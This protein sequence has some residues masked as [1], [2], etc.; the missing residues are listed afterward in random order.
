M[1]ERFRDYCR[2]KDKPVRMFGI[3]VKHRWNTTYLMLRQLKGYEEIISVFINSL[4]FRRKFLKYFTTI[5]HLYCFALV[6]DPRK[7]LE[8]VEAAFISIGDAVGLDYSEAYQHARDELFR[9]FR[10]YQTKLSVV[11]WVPEETPQKK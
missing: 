3:D 8:V 10:M 6:L 2:A 11:R 1:K 9:V 4:H 7:K 5:P